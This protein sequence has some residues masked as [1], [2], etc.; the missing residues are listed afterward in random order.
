MI[1]IQS[2][3]KKYGSFLALDEISCSFQD[4]T[5]TALMGAN[6]A[7]KSTLLKICAGVLP[8]QKGSIQI[9]G[10]IL[11]EQPEQVRRSI[12]YLPEMPYLYD[13]LTGREFLRYLA[14]LRKIKK[15]DDEIESFSKLLAI[16]PALDQEIN[17]YSKGMKQKISMIAALF[18]HPH[19]LLLDEPVW[20]LDPL[21]AKTLEQFILDQQGATVIATH[22]GSL[23]EKVADY[24]Y[25]LSEGKIIADQRLKELLTEYGSVEEAYFSFTGLS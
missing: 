24:V 13:R 12:G 18:H 17:G 9:D 16:T 11:D 15:A 5:V 14:S 19:N 1:T 7:G 3:T 4:N 23:V 10:A 2:L 6:G 20:G 25:F 22:S 8:Y 21:T